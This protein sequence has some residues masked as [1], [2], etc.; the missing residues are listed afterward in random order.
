[1]SD[2]IFCRIVAREIPATVV[3]ETPGCLAFRDVKPEA[4]VHVLVVPKKHIRSLAEANDP[5]LLGEML[6]FIR[7]LAIKE[8]ISESGYRTVLNTNVDGGQSVDHL[9]AHLLGGRK[10]SWPPG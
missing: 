8:G 1:M 7:R 4:P 5:P 6:D 2:C 10:L 3:D 9:H